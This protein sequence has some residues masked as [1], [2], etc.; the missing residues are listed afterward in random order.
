ME[1][2]GCV[3]PHCP[4]KRR[5]G[6]GSLKRSLL[7]NRLPNCLQVP[8]HAYS[9]A[10]EKATPTPL[11]EKEADPLQKDV[12]PKLLISSKGRE[13]PAHRHTPQHTAAQTKVNVLI[14][15]SFLG[16]CVLTLCP[17][18]HTLQKPLCLNRFRWSSRKA[19]TR[20]LVLY[21][22]QESHRSCPLFKD[23]NSDR[24]SYSKR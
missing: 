15:C 9:P 17:H 20:D 22:P 19:E 23:S 12:D 7:T 14:S 21:Y 4:E 13:P 24:S 16:V 8:G 10:V 1:P 6:P 11:I 18:A 5:A 3:Q 2:S